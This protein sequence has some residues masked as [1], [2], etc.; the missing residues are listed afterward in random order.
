MERR[1]EVVQF[2]GFPLLIGQSTSVWFVWSLKDWTVLGMLVGPQC[3][4]FEG[5]VWSIFSPIS[6]PAYIEF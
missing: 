1:S 5:V 2:K 4:R 3:S 6:F